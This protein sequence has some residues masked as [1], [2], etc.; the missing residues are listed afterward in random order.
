MDQENNN[1]IGEG[2]NAMNSEKIYSEELEKAFGGASAP[3]GVYNLNNFVY[4]SVSVPEGTL[5]VMQERPRGGFLSTYYYNGESIFVNTCYSE[6]GY[7][8]AYKDGNYGYVD[9]QYVR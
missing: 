9:A 1:V 7:L 6:A 4:R 8:I 3:N 2:G 5:L